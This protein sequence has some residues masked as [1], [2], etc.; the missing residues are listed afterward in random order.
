MLVG[1]LGSIPDLMPFVV[2]LTTWYWLVVALGLMSDM[3]SVYLT[4]HLLALIG[5]L[6]VPV[7]VST[8]SAQ[9]VSHFLETVKSMDG[10]T[11]RN[12]DCVTT[13]FWSAQQNTALHWHS[14]GV[15]PEASVLKP[16]W[17]SPQ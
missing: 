1:L 8:T 4:G 3:G 6:G 15:S 17:V 14:V 16:N 7:T 12:A 9:L 13:A 2:P 5:S 10:C 11:M